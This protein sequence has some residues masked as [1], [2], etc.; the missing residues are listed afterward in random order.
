VQVY[1][2]IEHFCKYYPLA[3]LIYIL[4][5]FLQ[6]ALFGFVSLLVTDGANACLVFLHNLRTCSLLL[7]VLHRLCSFLS[8]CFYEY[9]LCLCGKK[10]CL[11]RLTSLSF[12]LHLSN[13][14]TLKTPNRLC[15]LSS[16]RVAIDFATQ[17]IRILMLQIVST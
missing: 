6:R 9:W 8:W 14:N 16:F 13:R 12:S 17:L 3:R 2:C 15:T 1:C 7:V 10:R 5:R 11:R 4:I